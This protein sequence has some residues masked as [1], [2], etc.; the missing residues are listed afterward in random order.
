MVIGQGAVRAC[1]RLVVLQ[2]FK[3]SQTVK[4]NPDKPQQQARLLTLDV[5]STHPM[6]S[7]LLLR[8]PTQHVPEW[9][10]SMC[11]PRQLRW[12]WIQIS[13]WRVPGWQCYRYSSLVM[14]DHHVSLRLQWKFNTTMAT[15]PWDF[16]LCN[17][18]CL[19]AWLK[20]CTRCCLNILL[21][22]PCGTF[23]ILN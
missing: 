14:V 9:L 20:Y 8:V 2:E 23:Q 3:S 21:I 12:R 4:I 1:D 22:T 17:C 15:S 11:S 16:F 5:S 18:F 7:V 6:H 19:N 10:S 13:P